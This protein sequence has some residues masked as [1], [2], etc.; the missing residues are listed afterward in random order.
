ML[1]DGL[2]VS[3]GSPSLGPELTGMSLNGLGALN[4]L[5]FGALVAGITSI[6]SASLITSAFSHV[7]RM[8][9]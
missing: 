1:T 6:I 8:S 7:L 4:D 9:V 2:S 3:S 5:L